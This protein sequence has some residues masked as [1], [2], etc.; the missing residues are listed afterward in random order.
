MPNVGEHVNEKILANN[1]FVEVGYRGADGV[2]RM[3]CSEIGVALLGAERAFSDKA[4][5]QLRKASI[6]CLQRMQTE[7]FDL[8]GYNIVE[9]VEDLEFARQ[10]LG[11]SQVILKS[12]SYGTRLALLYAHRYPQSIK[13][14]MMTAVNP[15]GGMVWSTQIVDLKLVQFAELCQQD[16]Y[17]SSRTDDLIQSLRNAFKQ[18]PS[19]WLF[20]A[21]DPD[22]V[23][24][25]LFNGL[26]QTDMAAATFD[27]IVDA[28]NG[29]YSG[30]A[31]MSFVYNFMF[32]DVLIWGD[33]LLKA[34]TADFTAEVETMDFTPANSIIGSPM[35]Q[36][37]VPMWGAI[38]EMNIAMIPEK[39]QSALSS[40]VETLVMAA[41]LDVA[42]PIETVIEKQMPHLSNATLVTLE[43]AGHQDLIPGQ[44]ELRNQFMVNGKIDLSLIEHR[45][46]SFEPAI[47]FSMF[48][49]LALAASILM[50]LLLIA[51]VIFLVRRFHNKA[52]SKLGAK[53]S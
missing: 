7:G 35:M 13:R 33:S 51:L 25:A 48:A 3:D 16:S 19:H 53:K 32:G 12:G 44:L 5:R 31:M 38:R 27:M 37:G 10:Q 20:F 52:K 15:P 46:I 21:I 36:L 23:K 39:Y 2:T 42:T 9:V 6:S 41:D 4:G 47:G 18:V 43:H 14:S 24:V 40:D 29:D 28:E 22:R 26:Y 34:G 49:K 1:D 17:C 50:P 11:Y 8:N 45:K 30:F